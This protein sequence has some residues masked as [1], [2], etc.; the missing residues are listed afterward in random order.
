MKRWNALVVVVFLAWT[1]SVRNVGADEPAKAAKKKAPTAKEFVLHAHKRSAAAKSERDFA[2]VIY[3]LERALRSEALTPD[4]KD[5][6]KQ[7]KGWAHNRMGEALLEK[8]RE[9]AA[10]AQFEQAAELNPGHWKARHN[11][12]VSYAVGGEM[13]KALKDFSKVVELKPKFA[14]AW[15]NRA[16]ANLALGNMEV[17]IRDYSAAIKLAPRDAGFYFARAGAYHQHGHTDRALNDYNRAIE[18]DTADA[19]AYVGRGDVHVRIGNHEEAAADYRQALKLDKKS[20]DAYRGVAWMMATSPDERY[21]DSKRAVS[22]AQRAI[23]L[24]GDGDFRHFET[25]AAAYAV[26]GSFDE[27]IGTQQKAISMAAT[28]A[29]DTVI[30]RLRGSLAHYERGQ[31]YPTE[32]VARPAQRDPRLR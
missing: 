4:Y 19:A 23:E 21:R 3:L 29:S 28:D 1:V 6:A 27:A 24:A 18:L 17:A 30:S 5:Y 22:F 13:G 16:E 8:D 20:A 31:P 12:G 15:F 32:R 7:L 11:R 9:T 2:A 25:L 14:N 26:A 10:L